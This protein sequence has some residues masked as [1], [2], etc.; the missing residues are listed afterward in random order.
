MHLLQCNDHDGGGEYLTNGP[1][2]EPSVSPYRRSKAPP[3]GWNDFF[4][5]QV[6]PSAPA[7]GSSNINPP[8][9]YQPPGLIGMPTPVAWGGQ[10]AAG[11]PYGGGGLAA[12]VPG[13]PC[14]YPPP[15]QGATWGGPPAPGYGYSGPTPPAAAYGGSVP[16]GPTY[17]GGWD[18]PTPSQGLNPKGTTNM[19][20]NSILFQ[21]MALDHVSL[22]CTLK[23]LC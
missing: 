11:A 21:F 10:P 1:T 8:S 13:Y 22:H 16:P 14:G 9:L 6:A 15:P 3:A 17:G 5:G 7:E 23:Q 20:I 19:D 12:P 2:S 18:N 4:N